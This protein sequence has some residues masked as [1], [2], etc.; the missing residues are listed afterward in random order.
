MTPTTHGNLATMNKL[1]T[2]KRFLPQQQAGI[3]VILG[4]LM[5]AAPLTSFGKDNA[6]ETSSS[7]TNTSAA[8]TNTEEK[9]HQLPLS[10]PENLPW[11]SNTRPDF[12]R[13]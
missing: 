13:P 6:A 1:R 7:E 8:I 5:L 3:V 2:I 12:C 4:V 10:L 9:T 11:Q